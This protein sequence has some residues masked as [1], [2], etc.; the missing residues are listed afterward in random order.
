MDEI[1]QFLNDHDGWE[2]DTTRPALVKSFCFKDF[3]EA[4]SWMTR[5]ALYAEKNNHHP[6]WYNVWNKVQVT[7]TTHDT[8]S[9]TERDLKLARFMDQCARSVR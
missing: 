2:H 7:L 4:F 6:E 9:V 8:G 1:V 5:V 3:N